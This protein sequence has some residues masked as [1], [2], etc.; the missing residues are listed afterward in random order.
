MLGEVSEAMSSLT[1]DSAAWIYSVIIGVVLAR[2]FIF[3]SN[4]LQ[5]PKAI[6][7]YYPYLAFTLANILH[8]YWSWY[9]GKRS[10]TMIEGHTLSF[11]LR[12]FTDA[13]A[14]IYGLMIVPKDKLLEDFFDMKSWFMKIKKAYF[15]ITVLNLFVREIYFVLGF[16]YTEMLTTE[17]I[18]GGS[19]FMVIMILL[20]L[21][22]AFSKNDYYLSF[23]GTLVVVINSIQLSAL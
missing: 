18:I 8:L 5:E 17:Q 19:V 15:F 21:V 7:L 12:T 22:S 4:L 2:Y 9:T 20:N 13:I 6:K 16:I 10:Y 11:A 23:H 1:W 3:I 14:C